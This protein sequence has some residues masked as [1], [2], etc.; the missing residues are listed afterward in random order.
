MIFLYLIQISL[1]GNNLF[2]VAPP[3]FHCYQ[4]KT[5]MV[6]I[7]AITHVSSDISRDFNDVLIG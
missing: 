5:F 6:I 7:C 1:N 3:I 2:S 4:I